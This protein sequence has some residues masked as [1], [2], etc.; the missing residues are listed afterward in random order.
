M[1]G[2]ED[3]LKI[4]PVR[5]AIAYQVAGKA[6]KL[7]L[8]VPIPHFI[9]VVCGWKDDEVTID[10]GEGPL[11][12]PSPGQADVIA[13]SLLAEV[14]TV[15]YGAIIKNTVWDVFDTLLGTINDHLGR[16][17]EHVISEDL[18]NLLREKFRDSVTIDGFQLWCY[19]KFI[20]SM[21]V[22]ELRKPCYCGL[23]LSQHSDDTHFHSR[24]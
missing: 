2:P 14:E 24:H 23:R 7:Y 15:V 5:F 9:R 1:D 10:N 22:E 4:K 16:E 3:L 18:E 21:I 11:T 17:Y 20:K 8:H 6:F 12:S 19:A 13:A